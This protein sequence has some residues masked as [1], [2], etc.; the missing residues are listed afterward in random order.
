MGGLFD[1]VTTPMTWADT[2]PPTLSRRARR[3]PGCPTPE[4]APNP[5]SPFQRPHR[6]LIR[7]G[8]VHV[9]EDP[10]VGDRKLNDR[11]RVLG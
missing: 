7:V 10:P 11:I 9:L 1:R 2:P 3:S 6:A 4:E 5:R 8:V